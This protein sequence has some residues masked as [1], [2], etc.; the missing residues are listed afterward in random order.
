VVRFV[1]NIRPLASYLIFKI[2]SNYYIK[3]PIDHTSLILIKF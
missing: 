1:K 2:K 3:N